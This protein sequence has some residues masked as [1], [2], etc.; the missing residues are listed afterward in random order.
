MAVTYV[1]CVTCAFYKDL[2]DTALRC[3]ER[4]AKRAM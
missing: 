3:N 1:T 4:A 2:I